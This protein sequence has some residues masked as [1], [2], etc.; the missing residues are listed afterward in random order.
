MSVSVPNARLAIWGEYW[1]AE[2][3]RNGRMAHIRA[4]YKVS[5]KRGRRVKFEGRPAVITSAKGCYLYLRFDGHSRT[6]GPFHPR[7]AIEY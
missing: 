3:I 4:E 6:A 7:W 1:M 5:A 2:V